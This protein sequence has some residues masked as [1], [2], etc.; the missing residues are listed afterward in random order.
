MLNFTR[1]GNQSDI[2]WLRVSQMHQRHQSLI[3]QRAHQHLT[4]GPTKKQ[5]APTAVSKNI[6]LQ[7]D[8]KTFIILECISVSFTGLC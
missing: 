2:G 8:F 6:D 7:L 3:R 4:H 5:M 1:P